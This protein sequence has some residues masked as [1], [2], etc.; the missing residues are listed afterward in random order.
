MKDCP[1]FSCQK[2][3]RVQHSLSYKLFC[4]QYVEKKACIKVCV[5]MRA[6]YW[7]GVYVLYV[8]GGLAKPA[9]GYQNVNIF[10]R[11]S[12]LVFL[13]PEGGGEWAA[14]WFWVKKKKKSE[15]GGFFGWLCMTQWQALECS[16][17]RGT[18]GSQA[19]SSYNRAQMEYGVRRAGETLRRLG[20]LGNTVLVLISVAPGPS[21]QTFIRATENH[22]T[23]KSSFGTYY[24]TTKE[25]VGFREQKY[26]IGFRKTRFGFK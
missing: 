9:L 7:T 4:I 18:R 21:L 26:L 20:L 14:I 13:E 17:E 8:T 12:R 25:L 22:T 2:D 3:T 24:H 19:R 16:A 11:G 6:V 10:S 1:T 23:S 5:R 15:V